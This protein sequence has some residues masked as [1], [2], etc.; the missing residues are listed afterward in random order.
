MK[1]MAESMSWGPVVRGESKSAVSISSSL[2]GSQFRK[3]TG[4]E[5]IFPR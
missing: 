3:E 2:L 1:Y 4:G 5:I